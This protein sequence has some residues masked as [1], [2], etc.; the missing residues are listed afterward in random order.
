MDI[1]G[2]DIIRRKLSDIASAGVLPH[3]AFLFIGPEGVGKT[4]V[5]REFA[6]RLLGFGADDPEGA[7]DFLVIRPE[8]GEHKKKKIPVEAIREAKAFLSRF[9]AEAKRRVLLIEHSELL[10]EQAQNALLKAFEEPNGSSVVILVASRSGNIR[11]TII[12]R[13]FRIIFPL[14]PE[15]DIR[16]GVTDIFGGNAADSLEPFFFALGRPGIVVSALSDP[17][18]FSKRKDIL[19]SLFRISSLPFHE[20]LRLSE[21]LSENLGETVALFALWT[22]GLRMLRKDERDDVRIRTYYSFL[23]DIEDCSLALRDTNANARL[24]IDRLFLSI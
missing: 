15:E 10:S 3:E 6:G 24:L 19:R 18:A 11:D 9:P 21:T 5:A 16:A 2:H 23:E 20:R 14:V 17:D 13:S 8:D 1:I 22:T 12:S 4:L 7:Q